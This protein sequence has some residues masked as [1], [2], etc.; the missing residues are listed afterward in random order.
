MKKQGIQEKTAQKIDFGRIIAVPSFFFLMMFIAQGIF[1]KARVLWPLNI[2]KAMDFSHNILIFCFYV[3]VILL[4]FLRTSANF[5]IQS[6]SPRII[7]IMAS[8]APF[9]IPILVKEVSKNLLLIIISNII[10][11]SGMTFSIYALFILG[12][13]FSIIPQARGLV[14]RGPYRIVRHPLYAGELVALL[15]IVV[16]RFT[17]LTVILFLL[18]AA[19]QIYRAEQEESLLASQFPEY[20]SYRLKTSRFIPGIF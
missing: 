11:I 3:L 18:I 4:Y 14:Q 7:A 15:G 2:I 12:K 6:W 20:E 13:N 17:L 9:F 10:M 1:L 16:A 19:C 5:T 8:I